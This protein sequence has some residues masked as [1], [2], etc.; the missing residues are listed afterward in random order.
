MLLLFALFGTGTA[1]ISDS[2]CGMGFFSEF[3]SQ[4]SCMN[5]CAREGAI[6]KHVGHPALSQTTKPELGW[7]GDTEVTAGISSRL[8]GQESRK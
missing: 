1:T 4:S 5:A 2:A 8:G 3:L 7:R 6:K